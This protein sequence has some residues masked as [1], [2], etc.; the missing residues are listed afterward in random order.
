M[1]LPDHQG[2]TLSSQCHESSPGGCQDVSVCTVIHFL[3]KSSVLIGQNNLCLWVWCQNYPFRPHVALSKRAL[4][5]LHNWR[6][7]Q[8]LLYKLCGAAPS[9]VWGFCSN[10]PDV[11]ERSPASHGFVTGKP[12]TQRFATDLNV[13]VMNLS[14]LQFLNKWVYFRVLR[15]LFIICI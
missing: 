1:V 6:W 11:S 10:S 8:P 2:T 13:V 14:R 4:P 7:K 3:T 12:K 5:S 9:S 15:C